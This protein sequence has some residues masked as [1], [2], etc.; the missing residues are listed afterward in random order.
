MSYTGSIDSTYKGKYST[1]AGTLTGTRECITL[2]TSNALTVCDS[3]G[4]TMCVRAAELLTQHLRLNEGTT[5][6]YEAGSR[7]IP[8]PKV[9]FDIEFTLLGD[10]D[11]GGTFFAQNIS[12][13]NSVKELH[14]AQ[15]FGA[16]NIIC[17]GSQTFLASPISTAGVYRLINDGVNYTLLRNGVLID[18][19]PANIGIVSE[20]TATTTIANRHD[21]SLGSYAFSYA[22]V[23]ANV[24]VRDPVGVI[25]NKY[26]INDN[27]NVILDT[28]GGQDGSIINGN[29]D[30][31]GLFNEQ[32]TLWKGQD[33]TV[34]PWDSIDQELLK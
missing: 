27:T 4:S 18:T 11:V 22:G 3:T 10:I 15:N 16:L 28:I 17:G 32:P 34:P 12:S 31:W 7:L 33:L 20:P 30:D 23:I 21:N 25:T 8:D 29:A 5:D 1:T 24:I 9:H 13:S 26:P 14:V 19:V 6:G 2:L